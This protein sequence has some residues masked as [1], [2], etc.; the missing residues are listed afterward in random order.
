MQ[1]NKSHEISWLSEK[2]QKN[3]NIE[4]LEWGSD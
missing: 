3:I 4:K 1:I 2:R